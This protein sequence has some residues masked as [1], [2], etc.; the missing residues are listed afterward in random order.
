[1]KIC[2]NLE[3]KRLYG[4]R[5]ALKIICSARIVSTFARTKDCLPLRL[6]CPQHLPVF[7]QHDQF[8]VSDRPDAVRSHC[9]RTFGHRP[10]FCRHGSG[11]RRCF[12]ANV[13]AARPQIPT[14]CHGL[15]RR[16]HDCRKHLVAFDSCHG[17][18]AGKRSKPMA[19]DNRRFHPGC[20]LCGAFGQ[21]YATYAP[22]L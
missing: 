15:C 6:S 19:S 14:A 12:R 20:S 11:R 3:F 17:T 4:T 7:L 18:R 2:S 22:G 16:H 1:M 10:L 9:C 13:A 21:D 5:F 8:F